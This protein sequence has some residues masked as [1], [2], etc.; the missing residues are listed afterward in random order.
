MP[1][2]TS[3]G[4]TEYM[5]GALTLPVI[6]ELFLRGSSIRVRGRPSRGR[7]LVVVDPNDAEEE[8]RER[9]RLC[10]ELEAVDLTGCISAV[11]VNALTEFVTTHLLPNRDDSGSSDSEDEGRLERGRPKRKFQDEDDEPIVL[12]S[13][14]RLGLRGVKSIQPHVLTPFV[15]SFPNLTHLDLSGTR[16]QPDLLEALTN[17]STVRLTALALARCVRLTGESIKNFLIDASAAADLRELNLYGDMTFPS[18]LSADDMMAIVVYAPCFKSGLLTYVDLSSCPITTEILLA[19]TEQPSLRSLGLSYIPDLP[20]PSVTSFVSQKTPNVEILT[21][22]AT[23]LELE[24]GPRILPGN[25][26]HRGSTRQASFALHTMLTQ[27]LCTPPYSFG[28][29]SGGGKKHPPPTRLRVIELSTTL[30]SGLGAGAGAWRIVRSKGGRGWYVDTA[31]GWISGENGSELCRDLPPGHTLRREV[32]K[33]ADANGN[34]SSGVGWHAR[35]MEVRDLLRLV[36]PD[37]LL[38]NLL[39][40]DLAWPWHVGTRGWIVWCCLV[41]ISRIDQKLGLMPWWNIAL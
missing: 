21:L 30:L 40:L 7:S 8:D 25:V 5:D 18:P 41:R 2:L 29:F 39:L 24:T 31:S 11:F 33:L 10:R 15:L 35:K 6:K 20:L 36:V 19:C 16:A 9:R 1:N 3:F 26:V 27:P 22:V 38:T 12:N 37:G 23:S 14:Q 32:D 34:V 13:L 4:A 28:H 17:S